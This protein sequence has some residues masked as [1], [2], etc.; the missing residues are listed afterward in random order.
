MDMDRIQIRESQSD[1]YNSRTAT[2]HC[3]LVV[4]DEG[5]RKSSTNFA[6]L[7]SDSGNQAGIH[8]GTPGGFPA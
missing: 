5:M 6:Q 8:R 7:Y 1:Y 4:T 2:P 3:E